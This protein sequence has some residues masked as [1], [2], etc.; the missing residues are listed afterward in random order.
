M[1]PRSQ[2][3]SLGAV[4]VCALLFLLGVAAAALEGA[5]LAEQ[6]EA[7][8]D[9][10]YTQEPE[11]PLSART[12]VYVAIGADMALTCYALKRGAREMNPLLGS[13][14]EQVVAANAVILGLATWL[15][16]KESKAWK[17]ILVARALP[18]VWNLNEM[19]REKD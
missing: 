11:R 17:W 15:V 9:A 1:S 4:L 14:C 13:S 7:L 6:V 10:P 3:H 18:V 19:R 2:Q 5:T 16:P 8:R 12:G